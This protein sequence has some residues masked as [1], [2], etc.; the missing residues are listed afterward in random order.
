MK[1]ARKL[2]EEDP[3]IVFSFL[4][5][6]F[7]L[8]ELQTVFA[9]LGGRKFAPENKRNFRLWVDRYS[10]GKG[11]VTQTEGIRT[12][13]HRPAKLYIPNPDIFGRN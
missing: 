5:K 3:E 7:T 9:A 13:P 2:I 1:I 6:E 4:Q 8:T 10:D 12:G 11:L